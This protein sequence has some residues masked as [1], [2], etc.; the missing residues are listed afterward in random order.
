MAQSTAQTRCYRKNEPNR[1]AAGSEHC[2]TRMLHRALLNLDAAGAAQLGCCQRHCPASMLHSARLKLDPAHLQSLAECRAGNRQG[3]QGCKYICVRPAPWLAFSMTACTPLKTHLAVS[4]TKRYANLI[5]RIN[6]A[7]SG[8]QSSKK[9]QAKQ[10][11]QLVLHCKKKGEASCMIQ[12]AHTYTYA[13]TF[14][15]T[16][17]SG[18]PGTHAV[19]GEVHVKE[20]VPPNICHNGLCDHRG[21]PEQATQHRWAAQAQLRQRAPFRRR[22]LQE[23]Q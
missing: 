7:R 2:S 10:K 1:D 8:R 21:S 17:R 15:H 22:D 4:F 3:R 11:A 6:A 20:A 12:R 18:L 13:H 19:A 9:K 5:V 23:C 14:T 16:Q